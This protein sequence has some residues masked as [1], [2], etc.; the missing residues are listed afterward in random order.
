MPN[1]SCL[2]ARGRSA[3]HRATP[4]LLALVVLGHEFHPAPACGDTLRPVGR[5]SIEASAGHDDNILGRVSAATTGPDTTLSSPFGQ[6]GPFVEV[7]LQN[8]RLELVAGYS[9]T[10]NGFTD[11]AA[12]GYRDHL[13][14]LAARWLP[15]ARLALD[16]GGREERFRRTRFDSY[17]LDHRGGGAMLRFQADDRLRLR[18][19][20][21]VAR[22]AYPNS[23]QPLDDPIQSELV[24]PVDL[25]TRFQVGGT[26]RLH[27]RLEAR[28]DGSLVA[29]ASTIP[30]FEFTGRRLV[31]AV[32][33]DPG[34]GLA[35]TLSWSRESRDYDAYLIAPLDLNPQICLR[36][37]VRCDH[38]QD[39]SD[40]YALELRRPISAR[41]A[42]EGSWSR[43]NYRSNLDG[44][45]F[46][47]NRFRAGVEIRL[48]RPGSDAGADLPSSWAVSSGRQP[49]ASGMAPRLSDSGVL[50]RCRAPGATRVALLGSFNA[51]S[52]TATPLTDPDGDGTWDVTLPVPGGTHRYM[53]LVDGTDWRSPE[54]AVMYEDDGFG[55]RNGIV[56]VP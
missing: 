50:F 35:L 51:W 9:L 19:G 32:S 25:P 12:G 17:D 41:I 46:D 42:F 37:N 38:R 52:A 1:L 36:P 30:R 55:L 40:S 31:A 22:D 27:P 8:S 20:L 10:L 34:A 45:S 47:Q 16:V 2:R 54:D 33:L 4:W 49:A 14:T 24:V 43:L 13:V 39:T 3:R 7:G 29:T 23:A 11:A 44:F 18:C 28:L 6:V 53:F 26:L 56:I 21:D 48:A 15:S 5:V